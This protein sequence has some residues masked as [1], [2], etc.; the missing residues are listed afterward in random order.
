[1]GHY[2]IRK[3]LITGIAGSGGSY[4][5]E[6]IVNNH[7]EVEVHG[8]SRWHSTTTSDNLQDVRDQVIMHECDLTDFSSILTVLKNVRPDAIFHLASH[9]NVRTSFA[10]PL[11]VLNNNIMSTANLFE[12]V[13]LAEIDPIIQLCSTSEVY[14]QVSEEYV[15]IKEDT[16][17]RPASPYAVSKVTQDL[18]GYTYFASYGMKI[19]RTRM[20]AYLNPRRTDLFA[21]SFAKQVA[22]IEC[23][24]QKELVHG[25]LDSV[26]T[27]I[28][29]RD[30]MEAY[31]FAILY[32]R[33]G[34][35]YN[36]GGNTVIKVGDFLDLLKKKSGTKI[37]SRIDPNLLRP[38]DVT[39][40]IPSIEKF[41]HAT[42][43]KPRYSFEESVEN[44]LEYW[45]K[46]VREEMVLEH[47]VGGGR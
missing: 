7:P 22:R 6:Y 47:S 14:G 28:D 11:S 1:M 41:H 33:P 46:K 9:A 30:A 15:P 36:I 29:V 37:P 16:P 35:A 26:R 42:G 21:T 13:R 34:E 38:A 32:C 10:T 43:W 8:V 39:L 44:L 3:V 31:W 4:L 45:R 12:A 2:N 18:L 27:I 23:G 25:N 24:I 19:I 20:F 17:I 40:Q 5:A